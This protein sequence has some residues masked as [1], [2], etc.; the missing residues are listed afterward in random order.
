MRHFLSLLLLTVSG[1][2]IAADYGTLQIDSGERQVGLI[3]L[4]TS[5][6]CSSC[7]PADKWMTGLKE[8]DGLWRDYVPIAL[9]VDYWN[10]I[11]WTDRFSNKRYTDRQQQYVRDG[12]VNVAYTPGFFANGEEW[13]GWFTGK[14]LTIQNAAVGNL[15]VGVDGDAI[16]LRFDPVANVGD[17]LVANIAILGMQLQSNV[18][19]GEN[20]GK[21]LKHDFVALN[22]QTVNL[23]PSSGGFRAFTQLDDVD[24]ETEEL[25]IVAWV[26]S[27][28]NQTP[29]QTVGSYLPTA[30]H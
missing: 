22:V 23:E 25:A 7:P 13:R 2:A 15:S 28:N 11:G 3:E 16:A 30:K 21:K 17:D 26:S 24:S 20:D 5:E 14:A 4:Y 8:T 19:A 27:A 12:N 18:Q 6:G 1:T 9:H 10:Y 29:L